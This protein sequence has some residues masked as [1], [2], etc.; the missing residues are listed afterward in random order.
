VK[1][2]SLKMRNWRSY[3]GDQHIEFSTD[4]DKPVTLLLGPNGAGKTALLNAF[5]WSLYGLFTDGFDRHD[6]LVNFEAVELNP[7]A[8]TWVEVILHHDEDEYRVKRVTDAQRQHAQ[9]YEVTVTKNGERGVEDDIHRILPKPL[10]D[11]FFFPAET[12]STASVLK[13]DKPG[14]GTSFDL[15]TAIRSLLSGDIYDHASTDLRRAMES[16]TLKPP[17][18]YRDETV[19]RAYSSDQQ[20][21]KE[22]GAIEDR[23]DCLP[24]LLATA[25]DQAAKAKQ[26][27][28]RYDPKEMQKWQRE[29]ERLVAHVKEAQR[30]VEQADSLFVELARNAHMHFSRFAVESAIA[31][32]DLAEVA[33]LMPPRIHETV[34]EKALETG[35]CTLC[36]EPLGEE[37]RKRV[38]TLQERSR[39]SQVAVR[40]LEKRTVLKL[41]LATYQTELERLREEVTNLA[42]EL[43]VSVPSRDADMKMLRA[44]VHT[45]IDIADALL[46][47][48]QREFDEFNATNEVKLPDDGRSPV[49]VAMVRQGLVDSL[50]R[51]LGDIEG[52]I[53]KLEQKAK[54]A[55]A[56]YQGKSG[57][58][59]EHRLKTSAIEIL[60]EAKAYFDVARQ[61]LE[62]FGREDFQN[63][64]NLTYSDMISKPF[65]IQVGSDFSIKVFQT[66]SGAEMPLSQS[67]KVLLLIAFLGA[68]ARLAPHYEQIAKQSQ[69]LQLTGAVKT[70]QKTGFPVVLDAPTSP[71][72]DEYEVDVVA[73]LPRLL[74]Q[75]IVPVSA[76]SV[77]VWERIESEIGRT[78]VMELTSSTA[79][80]RTVRWRGK[81]YTYCVEDKGVVP[82]RT[83][84]ISLE[85]TEVQH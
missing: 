47:K 57:K 3:H 70:S 60:Q 52:K 46:T 33:G 66:G 61:G 25:R 81:D 21:R 23:R 7:A 71:L 16:E 84:I 35:F 29:H 67:E 2:I 59:E 36:R 77:E 63:A 55:F 58:S 14:E 32:L 1:F 85:T 9:E 83:R 39:D 30:A 68:I 8:E 19:D 62:E 50:D 74:P 34:L 79:T 20:A 72:D 41:F 11:L 76:K 51:E 4:P 37:S 27:A 64:I 75:V 38:K 48:N 69:Q 10:K 5:T 44:V 78:Y 82:A 56:D 49:E 65:E 26:E 73:A 24:G 40:G 12:F 17:K 18:N 54:E 15:G 6:S 22:L 13:G 42:N 53:A 45:C 28:S 31:R 80:N 43:D